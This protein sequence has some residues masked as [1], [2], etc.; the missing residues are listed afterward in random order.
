LGAQVTR[1]TA[2]PA[3]EMVMVLEAVMLRVAQ[4]DWSGWE[5]DALTPVTSIAY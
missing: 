4:V 5:N 1:S 2:L 3:E